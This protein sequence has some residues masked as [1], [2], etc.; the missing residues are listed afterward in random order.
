MKV[1]VEYSFRL[2]RGGDIHDVVIPAARLLNVP[3]D[4][5]VVRHLV[6]Q[7]ETLLAELFRDRLPEYRLMARDAAYWSEE[8]TREA[9]T[10]RLIEVT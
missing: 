2:G 5:A 4:I 10:I 8:L 9:E 1:A 7:D 6:E 3:L